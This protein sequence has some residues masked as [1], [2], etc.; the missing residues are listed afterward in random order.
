MGAVHLSALAA[1]LS[2]QARVHD[3]RETEVHIDVSFTEIE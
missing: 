3:G 2:V 1:A